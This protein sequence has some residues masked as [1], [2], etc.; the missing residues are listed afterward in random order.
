VDSI[1]GRSVSQGRIAVAGRV[2]VRDPSAGRGQGTGAQ[3]ATQARWRTTQEWPSTL[4]SVQQDRPS[5]WHIGLRRAW[6][7]A[8]HEVRAAPEI[9]N[10]PL[11]RES[12]PQPAHGRLMLDG[13]ALQLQAANDTRYRRAVALVARSLVSL[14]T[15][16][17]RARRVVRPGW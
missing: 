12:L 2:A 11:N 7:I 13:Q 5:V 3:P 16:A 8:V 14:A 9:S 17:V 6:V 10:C 1:A 15:V 4:A